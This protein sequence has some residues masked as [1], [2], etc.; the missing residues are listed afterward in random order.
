L[1]HYLIHAYDDPINGGQ[2]NSFTFGVNWW[3]NSN[4]GVQLNYDFTER[5]RV[6]TVA[7]NSIN[8]VG[9]RFRWDF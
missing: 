4:A 6:K 5:S 3:W 7:A 1:A 2:L 9:C 8:A